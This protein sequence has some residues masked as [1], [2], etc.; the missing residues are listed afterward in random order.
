[1]T[2]FSHSPQ[3]S[4]KKVDLRGIFSLKSSKNVRKQPIYDKFFKN[5]PANCSF[6]QEFVEK[7]EKEKIIDKESC[8]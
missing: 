3:K 7:R 5:P 4:M 2:S 6:S 8:Q 1:M